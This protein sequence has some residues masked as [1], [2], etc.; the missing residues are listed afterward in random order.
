MATSLFLGSQIS[1]PLGI[2][3]RDLKAPSSANTSPSKAFAVRASSDKKSSRRNIL[4]LA[5]A[6]VAAGTIAS[7]VAP[8]SAVPPL[9][10]ELLARSEANKALNDAKRLATSGA[11]GSRAWTVEI[12]SCRFPDNFTGCQ[13]LARRKNVAFL[14]DDLKLECKGKAPGEC[15][16]NNLWGK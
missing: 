15:A 16:S 6:A 3:L 8:A 4:R 9:V 10:E 2:A 12:G 11:N 14:S 5:A 13:D 1:S 7:N